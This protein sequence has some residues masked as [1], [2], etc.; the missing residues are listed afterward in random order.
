MSEEQQ[1]EFKVSGKDLKEKVK[2]LINEGNARKLIIK[3]EQGENVLEIPLTWGAVGVVLAP[4]LAA[5]G[6][7]AAVP[8][9][10]TVVVVKK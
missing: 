2:Q 4:A 7:I 9:N 5:V 1:E 6:A 10:C 8:T 3:N